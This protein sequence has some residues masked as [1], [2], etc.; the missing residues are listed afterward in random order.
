MIGSPIGCMLMPGLNRA[1]VE[2]ATSHSLVGLC[3]QHD[4]SCCRV[5][6][7]GAWMGGGGLGGVVGAVAQIPADA[8]TCWKRISHPMWNEGLLMTTANK[9]ASDLVCRCVCCPCMHHLNVNKHTHT[10]MHA[11]LVPVPRVCC[12]CCGYGPDCSHHS[13]PCSTHQKQAGG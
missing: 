6:G 5:R 11:A 12:C 3:T 1:L 9:V 7:V 13:S 10:C 4:A 2:K 8:A